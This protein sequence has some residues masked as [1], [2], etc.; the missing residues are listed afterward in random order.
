MGQKV[1]VT[2][3][4]SDPPFNRTRW[5][6]RNTKTISR[7]LKRTPLMY[8]L[9]SPASC[10]SS[11]STTVKS[12]EVFWERNIRPAVLRHRFISRADVWC[13]VYSP[14]RVRGS[15][16]VVRNDKTFVQVYFKGWIVM[17]DSIAL[18]QI[19]LHG[20][21]YFLRNWSKNLFH[22]LSY[23]TRLYFLYLLNIGKWIKCYVSIK[24]PQAQ[25]KM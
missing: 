11:P 3:Q 7:N 8:S 2:L 21:L 4:S 24:K 23:M 6:E 13:R 19:L 22:F 5:H 17:H 20:R 14:V 18:S 12:R 1:P 16:P 9:T 15:S 10:S 25:D